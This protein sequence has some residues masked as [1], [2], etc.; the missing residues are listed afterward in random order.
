MIEE[1]GK[2]ALA[3]TCNVSQVEDVRLALDK[4]VETFG[5]LNFAF[6]NAGVEQPPTP[7]ADTAEEAWDRVITI[8]LGGWS[9]RI[10]GK[11]G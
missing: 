11:N 1:L 2:R 10:M 4:A 8:N 3:V 7:T 5:R 6:N 9:Y